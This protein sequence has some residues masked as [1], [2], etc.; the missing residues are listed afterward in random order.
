MNPE[1]QIRLTIKTEEPELDT[2]ELRQHLYE[3]GEI[4]FYHDILNPKETYHGASGLFD[5]GRYP[6]LIYL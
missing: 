3:S 4:A 2:E 5:Q 1:N 6:K